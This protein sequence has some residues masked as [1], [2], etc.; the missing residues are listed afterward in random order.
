MSGVIGIGEVEW[1]GVPIL[2]TLVGLLPIHGVVD[3]RVCRW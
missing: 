3:V 2:T 1:R